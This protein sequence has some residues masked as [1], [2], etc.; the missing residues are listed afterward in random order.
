MSLTEPPE[1]PA[2]EP[3]PLTGDGCSLARFLLSQP[4]VAAAL[5]SPS[6]IDVRLKEAADPVSPLFADSVTVEIDAPDLPTAAAVL[7]GLADEQACLLLR[8][9][10]QCVADYRGLLAKAFDKLAL[11][12]FLIV[13]VPHQFL[14]ERKLQVPSRYQQAHLRFYTPGT[15]LAEIEE[16]LDPCRYRVRLLA[17]HDAGFDYAASLQSA[18]AG[19]HEIV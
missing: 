19:G 18:A 8:N 2:A 7:D 15:L 9:V 5:R 6:I 12:G 11:G 13:I 1:L 14:Y 16:A 4:A 3:E 17:D 10:V